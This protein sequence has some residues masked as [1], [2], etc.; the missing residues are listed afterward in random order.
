M[1]QKTESLTYDAENLRNIT[2]FWKNKSERQLKQCSSGQFQNNLFT[3][4]GNVALSLVREVEN[5]RETDVCLGMSTIFGYVTSNSCCQSSEIFLFD[6]ESS[7]EIPIE[8]QSLWIEEN[9]CL[10][11]TTESFEFNFPITETEKKQECSM[12]S[13]D[14]NL[15]QFREQ[16]LEIQIEGCFESTCLLDLDPQFLSFQTILNGTSII[17]KE[18]NY[19]GIVTKSRCSTGAH[20]TVN[21]YEI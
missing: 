5:S 17:C 9:I 19:I 13:Y 6:L 4:S 21:Y 7:K 18:S 3:S 2:Q 8:I 1:E 20:E 11:N 12:L 16:E 15:G 14:K 10:I